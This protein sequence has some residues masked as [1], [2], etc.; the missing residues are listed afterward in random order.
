MSSNV[1]GLPLCCV[2]GGVGSAAEF[3]IV[4]VHQNMFITIII[5]ITFTRRI[6]YQVRK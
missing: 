6:Q 2:H 1:V 5:I 3:L 4:D